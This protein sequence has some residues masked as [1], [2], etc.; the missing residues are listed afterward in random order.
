MAITKK[1][2]FDLLEVHVAQTNGVI[3]AVVGK[4]I[5][6]LDKIGPKELGKGVRTPGENFSWKYTGCKILSKT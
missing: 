4:R 6:D 5:S 2:L 1:W 3:L